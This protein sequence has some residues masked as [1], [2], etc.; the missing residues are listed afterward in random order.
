MD[1]ED[2][3]SAMVRVYD[4]TVYVANPPRDASAT[5]GEENAPHEDAGPQEVPP[6]YHDVSLEEWTAIVSPCSR[7]VSPRR[8]FLPSQRFLIPSRMPTIG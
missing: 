5:S 6:P 3:N 7:L 8:A 4:G 1:V 2:D